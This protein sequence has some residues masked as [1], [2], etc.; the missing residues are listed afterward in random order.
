[1]TLTTLKSQGII[2]FV[3]LT[4][5]FLAYSSQFCILWSF[6]GGATLHT[7][8]IL[9]PFNILVILI[10]INY[11][12]ACLTDPGTVPTNWVSKGQ[13]NEHQ[14]DSPSSSP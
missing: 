6:L 2:L 7:A 12:L 4:I 9:I 11:A 1:M 14:L 13:Q 10:Y 8:L 5:A 3:I